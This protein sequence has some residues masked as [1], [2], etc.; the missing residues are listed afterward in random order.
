MEAALGPSYL[1]DP[2]RSA[3]TEGVY[4]PGCI[5]K[6]SNVKRPTLSGSGIPPPSPQQPGSHT[7]GPK[8]CQAE[9]VSP[10][11]EFLGSLGFNQ[12]LGDRD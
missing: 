2:H 12:K 6:T 4:C 1:G 5:I 7:Q 9:W 8:P 3:Q 10:G 11:F